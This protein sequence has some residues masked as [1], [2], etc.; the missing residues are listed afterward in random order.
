MKKSK[1]S[2]DAI[3][4]RAEKAFNCG[5]YPLAKKEF[6]RVAKIT[7]TKEILQKIKLCSAE[8]EKSKAK[9][10]I[11][12]ARKLLKKNNLKEAILCFEQ[13]FRIVK[14]DWLQDK[15]TELREKLNSVDAVKSAQAAENEGKFK[16][17]ASLYE[18]AYANT[19]QEELLSKEA[20]CLVQAEMF[21]EAVSVFRQ[22]PHLT[23]KLTYDYGFALAN[24]GRYAECL[25]IWKTLPSSEI[26]FLEQ[27]E[28]VISLLIQ[29]LNNR[30]KDGEDIATLY[31]DANN[32]LKILDWQALYYGIDRLTTYARY[33]WIEE[34]WQKQHYE[35]IAALIPDCPVSEDPGL[36]ALAAKTFFRVA[37]TS[38]HALS[39]LIMYSLTALHHPDIVS[40][41]AADEHLQGV[42]RDKLLEKAQ[43]LIKQYADAGK[44]DAE[45]ALIF[46]K[47]EKESIE[48][49]ET[50][51]GHQKESL[52]LICTPL[53]AEL[54]NKSA[55][56][57][58]WVTQNRTLFSDE[59]HYLVTG[60][61]YSQGRQALYLL[62]SGDFEGALGYLDQLTAADEF[63]AFSKLVVSY[64]YGLFCLETGLKVAKD[65]YETAI[66]MFDIT[67]RHE[68]EFIAKALT[69]WQVDELQRFEEA[70]TIILKKRPT[71]EI[72]KA[73]SSV[74]GSRAMIMFNKKLLGN[75]TLSITLKKALD[76]D[77]EN[78]EALFNLH[79]T[80]IEIEIDRLDQALAR[81]KLNKAHS[82]VQKSNYPEVEEAFFEFMETMLEELWL[83][84][85][86][87][88]ERAFYLHDFYQ[89]CRK[90]DDTHPILDQIQ[91]MMKK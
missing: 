35:K 79:E 14:E 66:R 46:W 3:L 85:I 76:L 63:L 78:E 80:N 38:S 53:F 16:M 31:A 57:R 1:T 83:P 25:K 61:Y 67:P 58:S 5:N 36:L 62:E 50:L 52:H 73:L 47:I 51:L 48:C 18:K 75:K 23:P 8:L 43:H 68:K 26:R 13:A 33:F 81:Y 17:A 19:P 40:S 88:E 72:K 12:K 77:P 59:E 2:W 32:L 15:I 91:E 22:L 69:L 74:M 89:T 70:L 37:E 27:K 9:D 84:D 11:K 55:A 41:L 54:H 44:G 34:L 82:I 30:I 60:S 65:F 87:D 64:H 4:V 7:P 90:I 45:K 20:A 28:R 10:I 21:E 49:L 42:I 71:P 39:E 6:Q 86:D 24:T 29:N 56:I